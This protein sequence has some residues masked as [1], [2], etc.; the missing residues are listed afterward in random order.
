MNVSRRDLFGVDPGLGVDSDSDLLLSG[1]V[2]LETPVDGLELFAGYAENFKSLADRLLEVPGRSLAALEPETATNVDVGMRYSGDRVALGATWYDIDFDNR[3]FFLGPTTTAGPNYLIPGGGA[4]FNAGGIDTSGVELLAACVDAV[5]LELDLERNRDKIIE[6]RTLDSLAELPAIWTD[7]DAAAAA[8]A[9]ELTYKQHGAREAIGLLTKTLDHVRSMR[10]ESLSRCVCG[11]LVFYL[12]ECGRA[13]QAARVWRDHG[14]PDEPDELLD[15]DGQPWRTM[16]S[17]ACARIR[18][19]AEQGQID[20][21]EALAGRLCATAAEHGLLRTWL[22]GLALSPWRRLSGGGTR[23]ARRRGW[24]SSSDWRGRPSTSGPWRAAPRS[25]WLCCGACW[26]WSRT[27]TPATQPSRCSRSWTSRRPTA[28]SSPNASCRCWPRCATDWGTRRLPVASASRD[29]ACA[30]ISPTSTAR[31]ASASGTKPCAS[32]SPSGSST[33]RS[34]PILCGS[35]NPRLPAS[36]SGGLRH[37]DLSP[38]AASGEAA[39]TVHRCPRRPADPDSV[40]V[41]AK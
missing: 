37:R 6:R 19:L 25:A 8:V 16:E 12:A 30:S 36:S 4:Y 20:A 21:A 1:G 23:T 29:R 33:D 13:D 3:I 34:K 26:T 22:R 7:I 40:R 17:L 11:L 41:G 15:L 9:A 18:L 35:L 31:P 2:T 39:G 24:S 14:L 38:R 10:S 27:R 32:R 5:T 28:R